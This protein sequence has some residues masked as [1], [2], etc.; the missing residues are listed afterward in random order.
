MATEQISLGECYRC[1]GRL[2]ADL[3]DG[4]GWQAEVCLDCGASWWN[5]PPRSLEDLARR[6]K[7]GPDAD[8]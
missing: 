5:D 6:V 3:G 1:D 8:E 7:D 2:V 4:S